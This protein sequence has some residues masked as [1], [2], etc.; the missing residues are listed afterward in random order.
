[1]KAESVNKQSH[2][3]LKDPNFKALYEFDQQK[4]EIAKRIIAYRIKNKLRGKQ[5]ADKAG[6]T[7]Q[8]ISKIESGEFF[9]IEVLQKI[10]FCIGYTVRMQAVP[11]NQRRR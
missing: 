5:L 1:M 7:P 10:L 9:S 6:V 2:E 11:F 8:Y 3:K 4:L